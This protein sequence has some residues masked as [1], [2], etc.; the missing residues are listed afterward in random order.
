MLE[1]GSSQP[2]NLH[3]P[4]D[5]DWIR[6]EATAGNTYVIETFNLGS[7]VDTVLHL[8]SEEENE[9]ALDDNGRGDEEP[10]ASR[11]QW[12]ARRDVSLYIMAHDSGDED[13]GPGTQYWVRLLETSP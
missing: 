3:L 6:F 8:F 13:A 2:H 12:T 5:H 7:A 10:L 4:G 11:I 1:T 9:L